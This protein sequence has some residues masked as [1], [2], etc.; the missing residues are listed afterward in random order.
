MDVIIRRF[1]SQSVVFFKAGRFR[2]AREQNQR[3][4]ARVDPTV[5]EIPTYL[6][7]SC[8]TVPS[9]PTSSSR[10]PPGREEAKQTHLSP[11]PIGSD[12]LRRSN[13]PKIIFLQFWFLPSFSRMASNLDEWEKDPFFS[14]AEEVQDSADRY[15]TRKPSLL[16]FTLGFQEAFL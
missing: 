10:S 7:K 6:T 15:D 4:P 1:I 12:R 3:L 14:A 9:S 8:T 16:S 2:S 5:L 13:S 11:K